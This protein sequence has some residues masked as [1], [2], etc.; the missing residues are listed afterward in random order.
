MY[1]AFTTNILERRNA[2]CNQMRFEQTDSAYLT[3]IDALNVNTV[4]IM[5]N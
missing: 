4:L 5:Y 1:K 2:L 3:F